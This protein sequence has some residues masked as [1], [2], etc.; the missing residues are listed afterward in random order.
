MPVLVLGTKEDRRD[1]GLRERARNDLT[2][3]RLDPSP[4]EVHDG[5]ARGIDAV[6]LGDVHSA[7]GHQSQPWSRSELD[8]DTA[9]DLLGEQGWDGVPELGLDRASAADELE[10]VG[11]REKPSE[12]GNPEST[13]LP[14]EGPDVRPGVCLDGGGWLGRVKL[15]QEGPVA[16]APLEDRRRVA[17]LR[18]W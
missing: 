10:L 11:E 4:K 5:P 16:R 6:K 18:R 9:C 1:L 2:A 7:T 13:I 12:L 14:V 17:P 3:A 8:S 15:E